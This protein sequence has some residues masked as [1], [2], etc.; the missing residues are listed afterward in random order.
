MYLF[1]MDVGN[2]LWL[3]CTPL[4]EQ[5]MKTYEYT[6]EK[7]YQRQNFAASIGYG[8]V[9]QVIAQV[10]KATSRS[11]VRFVGPLSFRFLSSGSLDPLSV[12]K[13]DMQVPTYKSQFFFLSTNFHNFFVIKIPRRVTFCISCICIIKGRYYEI[14]N[15]YV[16]PCISRYNEM[17][18]CIAH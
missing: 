6:F 7:S 11:G 5:T 3:C 8:Q 12:L 13:H 4:Y 10:R 17:Y 2:L 1:T 15:K 16:Y 14:H 18:N 9:L